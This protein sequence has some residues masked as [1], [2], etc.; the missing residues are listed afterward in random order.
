MTKS[1]VDISLASG[2]YPA[3]TL[4]DGK[5]KKKGGG[6]MWETSLIDTL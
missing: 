2:F 3:E 4:E 6:Y 1:E 5:K